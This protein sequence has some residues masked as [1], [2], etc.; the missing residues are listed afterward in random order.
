MIHDYQI[1]SE[2]GHYV[3]YINGDFWCTADTF[4]EA[5]DEVELYYNEVA[6]EEDDGEEDD[7]MEYYEDTGERWVTTRNDDDYEV[8]N[9]GKV[10]NKKTGKLLK[11][12]MNKPNGWYRVALN[13]KKKYVHRLVLESFYNCD[14]K[15]VY[16]HHQDGDKTNNSII[17]LK[18]KKF[19]KFV[20]RL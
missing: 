1:F 16:I 15:G 17:N 18:P 19:S 2:D 4:K 20:E 14:L 3:V 8:S 9:F 10:R 13:G 6:F 11:P 12:L 7:V 5:T